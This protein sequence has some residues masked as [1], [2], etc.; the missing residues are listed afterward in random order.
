MVAWRRQET[1]IVSI[2]LR[3]E[4]IDRLRPMWLMDVVTN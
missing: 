2:Y 1:W 4:D 3:D